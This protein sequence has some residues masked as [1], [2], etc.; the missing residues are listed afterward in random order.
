MR[1]KASSTCQRVSPLCRSR[2]SRI[3]L[4]TGNAGCSAEAAPC[5]SGC[6]RRA[7]V[8][9]GSG[10]PGA[11]PATS[12]ARRYPRTSHLRNRLIM[13]PL[14]RLRVANTRAVWRQ[15]E[16]VCQLMRSELLVHSSTTPPGR[17]I[18]GA[19]RPRRAL[20]WLAGASRE[21]A[22]GLDPARGAGLRRPVARPP[23]S[24]HRYAVSCTQ[25]PRASSSALAAAGSPVGGI[26]AILGL[27]G[28]AAASTPSAR[29]ASVAEAR[30]WP[31][32]TAATAGPRPPRSSRRCTPSSG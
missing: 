20:A 17:H 27:H 24:T 12:R 26:G 1:D 29:C 14:K 15:V 16:Q 19:H 32:G 11:A 8:R 31:G 4:I 10:P 21:N 7:W 28:L 30:W 22:G 13:S 5:S 18:A 6:Q 25:R 3:R 9:A 23:F 2:S